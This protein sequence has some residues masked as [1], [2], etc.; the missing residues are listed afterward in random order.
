MDNSSARSTRIGLI[1]FFTLGVWI[2]KYFECRVVAGTTSVSFA[3]VDAIAKSFSIP[4]GDYLNYI[5]FGIFAVL[6]VTHLRIFFGVE[7]SEKDSSF[8]NALG[9][10]DEPDR[11]Q[12]STFMEIVLA[13]LAASTVLLTYFVSV[14][15]PW[16]LPITLLFEGV[17]II[18]F[19][20]KFNQVL[21]EID[22][23]KKANLYIIANDLL[24]LIIGCIFVFAPILAKLNWNIPAVPFFILVTFYVVI[25]VTET[26]LQYSESIWKSIK[27]IYNSFKVFGD[28]IL[29][30]R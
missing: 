17:L 13:I 28:E 8:N 29:S 7:F 6:I 9:Q 11:L 1:F 3:G 27:S 20:I 21:L 22:S 18:I 12:L 23:D 15:N 24:F 14:S 16:V 26:I 19:D 10:L 2:F 5:V 4:S 25:L 30:K